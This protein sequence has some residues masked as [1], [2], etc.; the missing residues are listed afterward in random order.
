MKADHPRSFTEVLRAYEKAI[1]D[2]RAF[3]VAQGLATAPD[4]PLDVVETPPFLRHL[5]PFAAYMGPARFATPRRGVYLVTP[6][7]ELSS[8]P[9]ADTRNVTVHEA[10][11]GHHLQLSVAAEKA[12]LAAFLCEMPDLTEGWALY[13]EALMGARGYTSAP[14]ERLVRARDA[15][16]RAVR[17]VLDVA[18]HAQGLSP[19]DAAARLALE[20]GMDPEEAEAE[21]L[22]YTQAPAYNLSYMWGR[23][24]I[25]RLRERALAKGISEKTF[26]DGLLALGSVSVALVA[27]ELERRLIASGSSVDIRQD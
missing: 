24:R 21:V 1:E 15:R 4:V 14:A 7:V 19:A 27:E 8:F 26:H 17:I 3:V 6:K 16:W 25:E 22:R 13:C 9:N 23:L 10:W 18:L 11:P 12:S 5:I 2:A 20:T